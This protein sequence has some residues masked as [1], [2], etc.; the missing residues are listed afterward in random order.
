LAN[1]ES[2]VILRPLDEVDVPGVDGDGE[3]VVS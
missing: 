2:T 3:D 1:V